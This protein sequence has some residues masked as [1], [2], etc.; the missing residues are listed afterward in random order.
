MSAARKGMGRWRLTPDEI[1]RSRLLYAE[2]WAWQR[3]AQ[4]IKC[5]AGTIRRAIDP[6]W[7]ETRRGI[8][9]ILNKRYKEAQAARRADQQA[10]KV[11]R[12]LDLNPGRLATTET[13][14]TNKRAI[15]ENDAFRRAMLHAL[16]S[17]Q[18]R[19]PVGVDTRPS[20]PDGRFHPARYIP[21]FSSTGSP[22]GMCA[23]LSADTSS[24]E[25]R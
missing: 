21:T 11:R 12:R 6:K 5:D 15:R 9:R 4:D 1:A 10:M 20:S 13:N 8:Q 7:D 16:H 22:A 14:E 2:G 18:E 19:C 3:I 17:K 25:H 23:E 24:T